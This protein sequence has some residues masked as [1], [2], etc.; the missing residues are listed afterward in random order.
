L[1]GEMWYKQLLARM[2]ECTISAP[3]AALCLV[4]EALAKEIRMVE[5]LRS[6]VAASASISTRAWA[7]VIELLITRLSAV[8]HGA[9]MALA[10]IKYNT[11]AVS[12]TVEE[13]TAAV[14]VG[15]IGTLQ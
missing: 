2:G 6:T 4:A 14:V 13:R 8:R 15:D 11:P 10:F 1:L 9:G 5:E 12:L 3:W 7:L